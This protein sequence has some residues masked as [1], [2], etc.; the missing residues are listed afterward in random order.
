MKQEHPLVTDYRKTIP[1]KVDSIAYLIHDVK[2]LKTLESLQ[3]LRQAVHKLAGN[4]GTYGFMKVSLACK[5][6]EADLQNKMSGFSPEII[7]D[8]WLKS[9]DSF[10]DHMKSHFKQPDVIVEF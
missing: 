6:L 4:S 5:D 3:A 1:E 10:L 9:L 7:T 2:L 8:E